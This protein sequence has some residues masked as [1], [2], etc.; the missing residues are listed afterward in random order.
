MNYETWADTPA[1]N[2]NATYT[3][4]TI[5]YKFCE[6]AESQGLG[7][8][9]PTKRLT[10]FLQRFDAE[11]Q[12]RYDQYNSTP[13][14]NIFRGTMMVAALSHAF[15]KDLRADFRALNFPISD[16]DWAFL[17]PQ[18][19]DVSIR[20][21]LVKESANSMGT[22]DVSSN[23][24][25]T[26]ASSQPW[27]TA[28]VSSGSGSK[29]IL[30]SASANT[31]LS[32]RKA[33]V[34]ITS[35]GLDARTVTITQAGVAPSLIV[36]TNTLNINATGSDKPTVGVVSNSSWTVTSSQPWLSV[37]PASGTGNLTV[38]IT[39]AV[40]IS[41]SPRT[42]LITFAANGTESK[43]LTVSQAGA[44]A[45]T[46]VSATT[47]SLAFTEGSTAFFDISSNTNWTVASTQSW[48]TVAP[49]SGFGNSKV[50]V[51]AALNPLTEARKA[52]V[53]VRANSVAD[54]TVEVSQA[55]PPV[56]SVSVLIDNR[57]RVFPN[58][59]EDWLKVEGLTAKC[60]IILYDLNG[61]VV[62]EATSYL[63]ETT[64]NI[65]DLPPGLYFVLFNQEGYSTLSKVFKAK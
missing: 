9:I 58:P 6:Y 22:F 56:T 64:I 36:S 53:T 14:A 55:A 50:T 24:D 63:P 42:A 39:A 43:S 65:Q 35:N 57:I 2:E 30:L 19:L 20:E 17:N 18:I 33:V 28:N 21:L 51:T 52:V 60:Q 59:A 5:G 45:F 31:S 4:G 49:G 61:K 27:L 32:P 11:W 1:R 16:T 23:V 38:T 62:K 15:Q 10:Q 46:N 40:N 44:T 25:W 48:L 37:N 26:L 7:Y 13:A 29:T 8:R 12:K 41:V 54:K 3:F 34:T 47:L